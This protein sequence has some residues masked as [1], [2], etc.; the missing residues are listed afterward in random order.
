MT[1]FPWQKLDGASDDESHDGDASNFPW[2]QRPSTQASPGRSMPWRSEAAT[3]QA[4]AEHTPV[5]Q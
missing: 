5:E 1:N 3:G 4:P 2:A